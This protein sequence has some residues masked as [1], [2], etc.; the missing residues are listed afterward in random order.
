MLVHHMLT[1]FASVQG[2]PSYAQL[3]GLNELYQICALSDMR[4][5]RYTM[6][7]CTSPECAR[8]L[9]ILPRG[10]CLALSA[11]CII[12]SEPELQHITCDRWQ[13]SHQG[14]CQE[15][16]EACIC[17]EGHTTGDSAT[18]S[19]QRCHT[20]RKNHAANNDCYVTVCDA[21]K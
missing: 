9:D 20:W 8:G 2:R 1:A 6:T 13:L 21:A 5:I 17:P 4:S 15:I 7:H 11:H 18:L 10:L 19:H 3:K 14:A 12:P 16:C